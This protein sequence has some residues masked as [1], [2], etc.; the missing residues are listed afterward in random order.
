MQRR[1][2]LADVGGSTCAQALE[3][4]AG[5]E[6]LPPTGQHHRLR[7]V[8]P[9]LLEARGKTVAKLNIE[10][11]GLAMHHRQNRHAVDDL[12]FDHVSNSCGAMQ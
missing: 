10:R 3:V 6:D 12:T 5:G 9:Q 8:F 2:K 11:I 7:V 4:D 1:K